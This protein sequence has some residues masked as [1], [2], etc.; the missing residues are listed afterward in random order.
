MSP[1]PRG[2]ADHALIF[3]HTADNS[4][5]WPFIQKHALAETIAVKVGFL[6]RFHE[7]LQRLCQKDRADQKPDGQRGV[8]K[9]PPGD[10]LRHD[11]RRKP[12][13]RPRQKH[14]QRNARR[15]QPEGLRRAA[16]HLPEAPEGVAPCGT[17]G[18]FLFGSVLFQN[19]SLPSWPHSSI[20]DAEKRNSCTNCICRYTNCNYETAGTRNSEVNAPSSLLYLTQPPCCSKMASARC[21]PKPCAPDFPVRNREPIFVFRLPA[22]FRR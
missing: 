15:R 1:P 17:I 21:R 13:L 14:R 10:D 8:R 12:D 16:K 3:S 7:F 6:N 19:T 4:S 5:A 2:C 9:A 20:K 11:E 22:A 18:L